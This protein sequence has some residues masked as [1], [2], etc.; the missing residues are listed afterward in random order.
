MLHF[1]AA[2]YFGARSNVLLARVSLSTRS[3]IKSGRD[4]RRGVIIY[5]A[6]KFLIL[7]VKASD[8]FRLLY[9]SGT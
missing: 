6:R 9:F 5:F 4:Q 1:D 3:K 2:S 8:V 7:A